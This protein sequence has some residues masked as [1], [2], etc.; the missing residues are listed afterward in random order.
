MIQFTAPV[1]HLQDGSRK[2]TYLELEFGPHAQHLAL[3]LNGRKNIIE[4]CL[5][6]QYEAK[7]GE[8]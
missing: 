8:L 5:P 2:E 7:I 6:I 4:K 1:L 3:L